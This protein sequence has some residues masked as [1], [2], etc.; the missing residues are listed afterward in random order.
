MTGPDQPRWLAR[1]TID[2]DNIRAAIRWT[3]DAGEVELALRYV[4]AMWR[5]WQQDGHLVEGADL[6]EAALAMPGADATTEHRL[7]AVTAAGGIAYWQNRRADAL[8]WYE[9]ELAVARR[10]G[11]VAGEADALWNLAYG[12]YVAEDPIGCGGAPATVS[13]AVRASR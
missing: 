12:R 3:I 7:A 1:L 13:S 10:L 5:Y 2:Y 8:R 11:H 9:E 4:A 6:A